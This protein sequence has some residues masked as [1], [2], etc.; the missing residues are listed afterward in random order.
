MT[1][2]KECSV[3]FLVKNLADI[4]QIPFGFFLYAHTSS[5]LLPLNSMALLLGAKR[6]SVSLCASVD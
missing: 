3:Q 6:L 2:V 4:W 5:I 1:P